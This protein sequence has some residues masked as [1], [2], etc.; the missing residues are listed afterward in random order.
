MRPVPARVLDVHVEA[1]PTRS[2]HRFDIEVEGNH[3]YFVDGVMVHNSPETTTGGRA[4]KFY[5]SVRLDVRRI[6]TLKD[7]TEAVGNRT[8]VKVVK[9]KVSPPFRQAEFD[10]LLRPGH[11]PRGRADRHGRR[12][13]AS[14]ASPALGTPTRATSSARARR[15]PATSCATTPTSPPRSR[16]RSRRSSGIGPR[17]DAA[18]RGARG[19]LLGPL[20]LE[21]AR[22][23]W[24]P[25]AR[26][27][28]TGAAAAPGQRPSPR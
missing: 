7:G 25:E 18:G 15:T 26:S 14:S 12:A 8:R 22:T 23:R 10:I 3:N 20:V 17:L 2:M 4:L 5:S 1:E 9:N 6:E 19:R 28:V 27:A 16:R 21:D 24:R 13:R 11:Q